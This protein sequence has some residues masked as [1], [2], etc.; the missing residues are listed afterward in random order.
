MVRL[1]VLMATVVLTLAAAPVV[2]D[3]A[4]HAAQVEQFLKLARADRMSVP[5]HA[6]VQ[7][8]FAQ[9]F[10]QAK[11][12]ADKQAVLERYQAKADA[13]LEGAV[14]WETLKPDMI[15]LYGQHFSEREL[16]E[17]NAFYQSALGRKVLDTMPELTAQSAQLAQARL[18]SV[19]PEVNKLLE[20]MGKELK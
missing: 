1:N 19:V 13:L 11:A 3:T 6:Q 10:A 5:V 2:A 12:P 16:K 7:Q 18:E 9:R 17:L 8:M 20:E 14:G 4:S 15:K